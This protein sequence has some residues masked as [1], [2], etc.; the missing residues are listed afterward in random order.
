[1][2]AVSNTPSSTVQRAL[3]QSVVSCEGVNG[4]GHST[5]APARLLIGGR[6]SSH[7]LSIFRECGAN[8]QDQSTESGETSVQYFLIPLT[9]VCV[10]RYAYPYPSRDI[11]THFPRLLISPNPTPFFNNEGPLRPAPLRMKL[12]RDATPTGSQQHSWSTVHVQCAMCLC[13]CTYACRERP[14]LPAPLSPP[15][16]QGHAGRA[17]H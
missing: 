2:G 12:S 8:L 9:A 3:A 11:D 7:L 10:M 14:P 15:C 17:T 6:Q 13:M 5:L 1:M 4:S 16:P